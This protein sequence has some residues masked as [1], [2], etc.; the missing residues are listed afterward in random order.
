MKTLEDLKQSI[1]KKFNVKFSKFPGVLQKNNFYVPQKKHSDTTRFYLTFSYLKGKAICNF[2]DFQTGTKLKYFLTFDISE[3]TKSDYSPN[4]QEF[5]KIIEKF[6]SNAE[7]FFKNTK[8]GVNNYI[9]EEFDIKLPIVNNTIY[10]PYKHI[11]SYKINAIQK[12]SN[13]SVKKFIKNSCLTGC[14]FELKAPK[15]PQNIVYVVEGLKTGLAVNHCMDTQNGVI[16]CGGLLHLENNLKTLKEKYTNLALC[17]EGK[18]TYSKYIELKNKHNCFLVGDIDYDDVYDYYNQTNKQITHSMLVKF[19]EP[20]YIA[21]GLNNNNLKIYLKKLKDITIYNKNDHDLLFSDINN[22]NEQI[23]RN[24]TKNF[25]LNVRKACRIKGKA[26]NIEKFYVGLYPIGEDFIY[27]DQKFCYLIKKN[28]IL[29]IKEEDL[30]NKNIFLCKT[31]KYNSLDLMSVSEL[32]NAELALIKE[33][34]NIFEFKNDK[35]TKK[36]ILGW[37]IQ[38]LLTGGV[39]YRTPLW[40]TAKS[41]SGKSQISRRFI[42]NCFPFFERTVGRT[43]TDKWLP[44]QFD[45]K[46]I[47]LHRDEFE[48]SQFKK[49]QAENEFE[50]MRATAT[51]RFPKRGI[52]GAIDNKTIEFTYCASILFSGINTPKEL[53]DQD[54]GRIMFFDLKYNFK[55]NFEKKLKTFEKFMTLKNKIRFFKKAVVN[56][57]NI[58]NKYFKYMEDK[59]YSK[60]KSHKKSSVFM[61]ASCYNTLFPKTAITRSEIEEA[62]SGSIVNTIYSKM[63]NDWLSL[64]VDPR[65]FL[66]VSNNFNALINK[67]LTEIYEANG[68]YI[69][70]SKQ[71]HLLYIKLNKGL[72]LM[73]EMFYYHN[74][75]NDFNLEYI[76]AT[77][78]KDGEYL[79]NKNLTVG[80]LKNQIIPRGQYI[81]F[82]FDM[83]FNEFN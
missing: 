60:I 71:K 31:G 28:K 17:L 6:N 29:K 33:T 38:A 78:E 74:K 41:F 58:N 54:I 39:P 64:T 25:Y 73:Q 63:L 21:L 18:S 13:N 36:F 32:S 77:L 47:P 16:V 4:N 5:V 23:D 62:L 40:I 1:E 53:K 81:V 59:E 9:P 43:S 48:P 83:V 2:G 79:V 19:I 3:Y 49:E 45:G 10:L 27:Y 44:R 22:T 66:A 75:L 15:E 52:S 57:H 42:F 14:V 76:K 70:K 11:K 67:E 68:I 26:D 12:I 34:L 37:I 46:A 8:L 72:R 50:Y 65:R 20:N 30:L 56:L 51:E 24:K 55:G 82:N 69:K 80:K 35:L 7:A 61:L